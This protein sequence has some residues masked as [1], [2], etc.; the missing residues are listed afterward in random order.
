[1]AID[2]SLLHTLVRTGRVYDLGQPVF[3]GMPGSNFHPPYIFTLMVR[4]GDQVLPDGCGAS[5]ELLVLSGHTGT[6]LDALGHVA[7]HG[8][9]HGEHG[10]TDAQ[11]GRRG[12]REHGIENAAPIVARGVLLD[13]PGYRGVELLPGGSPVTAEELEAVARHQGTEVRAGDVVLVRTGWIRLWDNPAAFRGD[14]TGEPGPDASA[15]EW[16]AERGV[17]SVGS[18]TIAFEVRPVGQSALAAHAELIVRHGIHI[19]EM[20]NC[21]E[22]ARDQ[23]YEFLFVATPLKLVGATGSPVRPIALT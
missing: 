8:R 1:M 3:P 13:V 20:V 7:E 12:L 6:H 10:A 4:H 9:I 21:E 2:V 18:D 16:L 11:V 19:L 15:A 14:T 23:V 22:L 17:H 5:N